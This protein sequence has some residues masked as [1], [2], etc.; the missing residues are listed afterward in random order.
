M[1]LFKS[2]H[3]FFTDKPVPTLFEAF[4]RPTATKNSDY[5]STFIPKNLGNFFSRKHPVSINQL[6]TLLN[7][8]KYTVDL[9]QQ[10]RSL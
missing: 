8:N 4:N 2:L 6:L 10:E 3:L 9:D 5:S 7:F 1:L